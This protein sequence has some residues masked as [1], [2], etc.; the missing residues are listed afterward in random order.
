MN[1]IVF[2]CGSESATK[3]QWLTILKKEIVNETILLPEQ[4]SESQAKQ[5][6]IAIVANPEPKDLARF[7]N[8]VWIQSLWAGVE[9]LVSAVTDKPVKLVRLEDPQLAKTMAESVLAW[10]FYLQRNMVE[11]A[12]QQTNKQWRQLPSISCS[13]LQVSVLGAGALGIAALTVLKKLDYQVSCWSRTA[14]QL[15]GIK[16]YLG[17]AGLHTMLSKTDI[18]INLLPL[19]PETHHLLG[20]DL[21][22]KLPRGAKLINFSRGAVIDSKALLNLLENGHIAHA[23]LDV[24]EHEPLTPTNAIWTNPNITVLP[25]ISAPTNM[26]SAAKVIA[27]NITNYRENNVIPGAVNVKQGY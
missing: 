25:H 12:K 16:N 3:S 2:I 14:K 26:H 6:D 7:P 1:N 18:L 13:E 21:L 15:D 11:Y 17:T 10:T 5:V 22:S 8:L 27:K 20:K 9:K 23:V 24:F 4:I 19:T